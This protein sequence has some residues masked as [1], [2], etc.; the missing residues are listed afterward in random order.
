MGHQAYLVL[1]DYPSKNSIRVSGDL[2]TP[3]LTQEI[4]NAHAKAK[5]LPIVI[6]PE[7]VSGNPLNAP[8][9]V[10]YLLNYAG[11][12][13]G[14]KVFPKTDFVLAFTKNIARS[15]EEKNPGTKLSTLFV[16]PVDPREFKKNDEKKD[17]QLVYAGKYRSFV[18]SPFQVGNLP[19]IEIF[20]EGAKMQSREEVKRLLSEAK[21]LYAFE[22]S[23]I[24]T[25]AILSGTPVIGIRSSFFWEIIAEQE[26]GNGGIRFH[27][28]YAPL[29]E[30]RMSVSD[31]ILRYQ[32][33]VQ[34]FPN[35][36]M[37]FVMTSS[38][39]FS[40]NKE[41]TTLRLRNDS[42][43]FVNHKFK[44]GLQIIKSKGLRVFLRM[45]LFYLRKR[46]GIRH[47]RGKGGN[48]GV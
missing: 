12:L 37:K 5:R 8:R 41:L 15:Y 46:I 21:V 2:M 14:D 29:D 7:T 22:N 47:L 1:S 18:E 30:A 9:V 13:G 24:I 17:Y 42:I 44:L 3:L 10:R 23:S 32:E 28:S 45:L 39:F 31:G 48:L 40:K 27:D 4:A 35:S 43:Q 20:R 38:E 26:T 36:L 34:E 16:P 19:S 6:Y 25:E 11:A 33:L